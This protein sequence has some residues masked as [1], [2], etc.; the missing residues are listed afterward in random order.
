MC[1]CVCGGGGGGGGGMGLPPPLL[2]RTLLPAVPSA[3]FLRHHLPCGFLPCRPYKEGQKELIVVTLLVAADGS[4]KMPTVDSRTSLKQALSMMGAVRWAA[5]EAECVRGCGVCVVEES[6]RRGGPGGDGR[7]VAKVLGAASPALRACCP[8][9]FPPAAAGLTTCL[10]WRCCGPL[11]KRCGPVAAVGLLLCAVCQ[12]AQ[13]TCHAAVSWGGPV[14]CWRPPV[15]TTPELCWWPLASLHPCRT[16]TSQLRTWRMTTPPSTPSDPIIAPAFISRPLVAGWA[17]PG[18]HAVPLTQPPL[19]FMFPAQCVASFPTVH[20]CSPPMDFIRSCHMAFAPDVAF[21]SLMPCLAYPVLPAGSC[22]VAGCVA[23]PLPT[24][25]ALAPNHAP[26]MSP[27]ALPILFAIPMFFLS[28]CPKR[29][30]ERPAAVSN[31][32]S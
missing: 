6:A 26:H 27:S 16:T 11:R 24:S 25:P 7:L 15:L 8:H 17:G 29:T 12:R 18:S 31:N 28:L 13:P 23:C 4:F 1:V 19:L 30:T 5:G 2:R 14:C 9:H 32:G 3:P 10:L 21:P 20:A 22:R